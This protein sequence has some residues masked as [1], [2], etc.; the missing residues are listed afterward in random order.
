M[1]CTAMRTF[2]LPPEGTPTAEEIREAVPN[3]G[4]SLSSLLRIFEHRLPPND[5]GAI[6]RFF[7][8][9]HDVTS[10]QS[11][12]GLFFD[13]RSDAMRIERD[14]LSIAEGYTMVSKSFQL[15]LIHI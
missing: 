13:K 14:D 4:I 11:K 6:D 15:S 3:G 2:H 8:M 1:A 5:F 10:R 12:T 9:L 7:D